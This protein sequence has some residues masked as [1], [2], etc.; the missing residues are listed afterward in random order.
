M[1]TPP[2]QQLATLLQQ[3][4][5]SA[6]RLYQ[7]LRDESEALTKRDADAMQQLSQEKSGESAVL[8]QLG[9]QQ[10]QLLKGLGFTQSSAGV[11]SFID[12]LEPT[13]AAELRKQQQQLQ[14][15][16]ESCQKLNLINGNII[17]ASKQSVETALAILR[18]QFTN[19]NLVY[20]AAGQPVSS[21]PSKPLSKA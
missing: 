20:S 6:E 17:A 14:T 4:A 15:L 2:A 5:M 9:A 16:L 13:A 10:T 19:N 8:E 3:Q 11:S 7:T 21:A 1:S 18:G 12:T